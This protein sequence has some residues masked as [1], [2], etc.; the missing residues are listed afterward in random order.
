MG[1]RWRKSTNVGGGVRINT[2][3][4]GVGYSWGIPGFRIG[5]SASGNWWISVGIP[6]TG[7]S[8]YRVLGHRD[9]RHRDERQA[10]PEREQSSATT[11]KRIK[12]WKDL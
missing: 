2:S 1:W 6:G 5:K 3:Q 7:L 10:P 4:S 11:E 9:L 8:F 12:E